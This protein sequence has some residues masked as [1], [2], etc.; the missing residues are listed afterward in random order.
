[1]GILYARIHEMFLCIVTENKHAFNYSPAINL[2]QYSHEHFIVLFSVT[3]TFQHQL[4]KL[5]SPLTDR[6]QCCVVIGN[7]NLCGKGE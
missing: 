5:L 1:M 6:M 2:S 7:G 4:I 3:R